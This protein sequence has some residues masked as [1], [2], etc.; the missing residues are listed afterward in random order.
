MVQA[1]SIG[2]PYIPTMGYAGSDVIKERDDFAIAPNPFNPEER[3]VVA[4]A[5]NPDVALFHGTKG[6]RWGNVLVR[7]QGEALMI[8]QAS[9][10]V[11]VTVEEIVAEVSREDTSGT[12]IPGIHVSAVTHAPFGAYPTACDGHYELDEKQ[13]VEYVEASASDEAFSEYLRKYVFEVENHKA[14]LQGMGLLTEEGIK[15]PVG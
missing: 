8:A 4:K 9:R 7:K 1:G 11:I 5:I 12:F 10:R 15:E 2:I 3:I 6:D 14:Y 13:I